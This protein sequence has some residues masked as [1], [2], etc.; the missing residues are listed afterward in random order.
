MK[1]DGAPIDLAGVGGQALGTAFN[2]A[3]RWLLEPTG[4]GATL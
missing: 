2:R 4:L 1:T 3:E